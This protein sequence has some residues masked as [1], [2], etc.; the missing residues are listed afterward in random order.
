[1][2]ERLDAVRARMAD[3]GIDGL[4]VTGEENVHYLTGVPDCEGWAL[5]AER[6]LHL[7]V[8]G[9]YIEAARRDLDPALGQVLEWSR[10]F[11]EHLGALLARIGVTRLGFEADKVSVALAGRLS[12]AL[13]GVA[14]VQTNG[15]VEDLRLVKSE[16]EITA[17]RRAASIAD[18]SLREL[19]PRIR[20]GASEV[21]L[22][23]ELE[24][25]MRRRGAERAAFAFIVA[26]GP[27]AALPHGRASGRRLERGDAVTFDIGA[28]VGGYASDMT[29]TFLLDPV[30][31]TMAQ[32]WEI[33]ARA[34][35]EAVAAVRPGVT[36]RDVDR[37]ARDIIAAAGYGPRFLHGTGHGVG[38]EIHEGPQVAVKGETVLRPGMVVTVEP[39][40]YIEGLGGV[41]IEDTVAVRPDGPEVLTRFPI[42]ARLEALES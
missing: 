8:D 21:D 15:F 40:I 17:I 13:G 6:T 29:R 2:R 36:G 35:R 7:V 27:R 32:V 19:L 10:P 1:M 39:G 9:R 14:L 5:V 16:D 11:E 22:A 23:M 26:S 33:V 38:L 18:E 3:R 31:A 20:P 37:V 25:I 41:R 28:V 24:W 4:L 42:Q 34:Q 30:D 12:A